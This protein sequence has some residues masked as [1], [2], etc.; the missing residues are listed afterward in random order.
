MNRRSTWLLVLSIGC[1]T[2]M[3]APARSQE[4]DASGSADFEQV[5]FQPPAAQPP[6]A[7]APARTARRPARYE[8][9]LLDRA[10]NMFGDSLPVFGQVVVDAA[11]ARYVGD[12]PLGAGRSFKVSEN[13]KP[14]PMDR[15]YFNYNGF[16]NAIQSLRIAPGAI[17]SQTDSNV[18]LFTLGFEKTFLDGTASIDIRMPFVSSFDAT[19]PGLNVG[20]GNVGDLSLF[21]KDL[22]YA[23]DMVSMAAGLGLGLPTGDDAE[24]QSF[25]DTAVVKNDAV[26]LM[27]FFGTMIV[28][29][30]A[31]FVQAFVELDFAAS[32]NEVQS[33]FGSFGQYTEQNLFHADFTFGR[34]LYDNPDAYY[35]EGIA[36]IVELHYTTTVNDTDLVQFPSDGVSGFMGNFNNRVDFLNL[37]G[38]IHFQI[39]PLSNLRIGC[40]VPLRSEAENRQFDSEIQVQFNRFL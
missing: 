31:W 23:D 26:H 33:R 38:G 28:P 19:M 13:N 3:I 30:E 29:N 36:A 8:Y 24:F 32:G 18:D 11:N 9:A 22:L 7:A 27:P 21:Y 20:N 16:Q 12:L 40:V 37:T 14:L 4:F 2:L 6:A 10:P 15:V 17:P 5:V 35:V 39:G 25:T 34:W 1:L